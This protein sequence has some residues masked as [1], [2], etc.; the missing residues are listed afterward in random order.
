[1]PISCFVPAFSLI[2]LHISLPV[3]PFADLIFFHFFGVLYVFSVLQKRMAR[4]IFET[5]R[6]R[7]L[8]KERLHGLLSS[9]TLLR[10]N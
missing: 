8:C 4:R 1:M 6:D 5:M 3:G 9:L 10:W 2:S 7:K